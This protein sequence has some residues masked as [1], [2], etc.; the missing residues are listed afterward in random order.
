MQADQ[1]A[2]DDAEQRADDES[3]DV[4]RHA[5][6]E[7]DRQDALAHEVDERRDDVARRRIEVRATSRRAEPRPATRRAAAARRPRPSA[8]A[9]ATAAKPDGAGA[10][11]VSG[12]SSTVQRARR[13]HVPSQRRDAVDPVLARDA[14]AARRA[15]TSIMNTVR[16]RT[17]T[18]RPASCSRSWWKRSGA[19]SSVIAVAAAS[20]ASGCRAARACAPPPMPA[21]A[22]HQATSTATTITGGDE[23][24]AQLHATLAACGRAA[25]SGARDRAAGR[26]ARERGIGVERGPRARV[27]GERHVDDRAD[28]ARARAS[29]RRRD[30]RGRSPPRRCA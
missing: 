30:R 26:A 4:A 11:S 5:V 15:S 10:G 16:S 28:A 13:A 17:S 25:A 6:G 22:R 12:R 27:R 29:S 21:A 8:R 7:I 9:R 3:R 23:R 19:K 20:A 1:H 14:R 2:E 18:R 24:Q